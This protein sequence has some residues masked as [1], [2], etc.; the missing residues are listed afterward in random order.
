MRLPFCGATRDVFSKVEWQHQLT[1]APLND[2]PHL[3]SQWACLP[4]TRIVVD[5]LLYTLGQPSPKST[6][7]N[8]GNR[9]VSVAIQQENCFIEDAKKQN[10]LVQRT[11]K[12]TKQ[13]FVYESLLCKTHTNQSRSL[14][15]VAHVGNTNEFPWSWASAITRETEYRESLT[16]VATYLIPSRNF[17]QKVRSFNA[18]PV[19]RKIQCCECLRLSCK[20]RID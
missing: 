6:A 13:W 17:P 19:V 15:P 20:K 8:P 12:E 1:A 5:C 4:S 11:A 7:F 14:H 16:V 18:D 9:E 2:L 3:L 10:F